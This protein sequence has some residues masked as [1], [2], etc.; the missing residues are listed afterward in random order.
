MKEGSFWQLYKNYT[1]DNEKGV[2]LLANPLNFLERKT[3]FED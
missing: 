2:S 1:V 3:G